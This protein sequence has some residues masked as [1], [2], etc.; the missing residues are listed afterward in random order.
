MDKEELKKEI[1]I[2]LQNLERLVREME[3]LTEIS[4]ALN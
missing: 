1:I 4:M 2:E 3:E